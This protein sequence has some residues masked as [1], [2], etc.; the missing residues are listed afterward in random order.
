MKQLM[1]LHTVK[2]SHYQKAKDRVREIN[3]VI[4]KNLVPGDEVVL[5]NER[6]KLEKAIQLWEEKHENK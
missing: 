6:R 1:E 4:A 2:K 5:I 3:K